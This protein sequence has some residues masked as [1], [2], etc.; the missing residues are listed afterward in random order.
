MALSR[1]PFSSCVWF[2]VH[3]ATALPAVVFQACCELHSRLVVPLQNPQEF[4]IS[5]KLEKEVK[6]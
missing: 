2:L 5:Q 6:D 3:G 1:A 4:S